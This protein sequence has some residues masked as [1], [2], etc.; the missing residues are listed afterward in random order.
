MVFDSKHKS[1]K[2]TSIKDELEKCTYRGQNIIE[3]AN[4]SRR[5]FEENNFEGLMKY[6]KE[7]DNYLQ[8]NL[9][10]PEEAIKEVKEAFYRE[11]EKV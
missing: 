9:E 4:L 2:K 11:Y 5:N 1:H 10:S 8:V 3:N 7:E 6:L